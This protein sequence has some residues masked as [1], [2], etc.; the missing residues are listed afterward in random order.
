[1]A[2][3]GVKLLIL[4]VENLFIVLMGMVELSFRRWELVESH[5]KARFNF[6]GENILVVYENG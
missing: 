4:L 3:A 1:M 5:K 6:V 2:T